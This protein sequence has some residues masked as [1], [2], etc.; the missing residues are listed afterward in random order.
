MKRILSVIAFIF[1]FSPTIHAGTIPITG[2]IRNAA[3]NL[4]NGKVRFS[5]T[6]SAASDTCSNNVVVA[7]MVEFIVSN[8][9]LP[10]NARITPNDCL[11]PANTFYVT[12]YVSPVGTVVAQNVF[13]IQGTSFNIGTATPTPLTTSNISFNNFTGLSNLTSQKIDNIRMCDQFSGS[14]AGAKMAAAIADLPSTG[15]T[16]DCRGLEGAQTISSNP[17]SGVTKSF[18]LLLS[19]TSAYTVSV[20]MVVDTV[21][22]WSIEA[23]GAT[24]TASGAITS[25]I[26]VFNAQRWSID[27]VN[28]NCNSTA[29]YGIFVDSDN[30]VRTGYGRIT[31]R[32]SLCSTEGIRIADSISNNYEVDHISMTVNLFGNGHN[33]GVHSSNSVG[34]SCWNCVFV[35]SGATAP[36][37]NVY[38]E[39]G[40]VYLY[41]AQMASASQFDIYEGASAF[42][43]VYGMYSESS[44]LYQAAAGGSNDLTGILSGI[45]QGVNNTGNDVIELSSSKG[46]VLT[47]LRVGGNINVATAVRQV[48]ASEVRFLSPNGFNGTGTAKVNYA[49]QK[50]LIWGPDDTTTFTVK[51]GAAQA[52]TQVEK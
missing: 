15:G 2:T 28:V 14:T 27:D 25:V 18:K 41:A 46:Y 24:L 3:G 9:T 47:G 4:F 42:L 31:G 19:P 8:G 34:I 50:P 6:Y 17:F 13:S 10:S 44:K 22:D 23:N 5:L 12:Q 26:K 48:T 52:A 30:T 29:S 36:T 16:V 49:P 35:A 33:L 37:H 43:E 7:Q 51:N 20:P 45:W 40:H 39:S 32:V 11:S 38:V 1:L 21:N